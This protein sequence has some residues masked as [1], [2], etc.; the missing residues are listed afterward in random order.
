MQSQNGCWRVWNF[1]VS[2]TDWACP[3]GQDSGGFENF[4]YILAAMDICP[5]LSATAPSRHVRLSAVY[6][7]CSSLF[8]LF[9]F[10]KKTL[11]SNWDLNCPETKAFDTCA[12]RWSALGSGQ[13]GFTAAP[14]TSLHA[15]TV[16]GCTLFKW[17]RLSRQQ[18]VHVVST[19]SESEPYI[20]SRHNLFF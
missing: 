11:C 10:W 15:T 3:T 7:L 14:L 18:L 2:H 13:H 19:S 12:S 9:P 20:I 17:C 8:F 6:A 4:V 5:H 16:P 1:P